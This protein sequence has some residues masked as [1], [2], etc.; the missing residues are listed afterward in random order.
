MV[1]YKTINKINGK[2][3]IGQDTNN[4]PNYLGSG[5]IIKK[6]IKK[7]GR[8]NFKKEILEEC[9]TIELL[10]EREIYWISKFDSMDQKIGY[11]ILKGG[12]GCSGFKQSD[13]SIIKIRK[14]SNSE[15]FKNIMR[16]DEVKKKIS[17]GQKNSELKKAL[18]Y[19]EEYREKMRI[20][21]TGKPQSPEKS[22]KISDKLKGKAKSEEHKE[23]L[24]IALTEGGKL[25]GENN[26][27]YNKK[28]T[29]ESRKK[30]T[31]GLKKYYNDRKNKK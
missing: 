16:S 11:N 21:M 26:P 14:N 25:L 20:S 8:S 22:K 5:K 28:H 30:M 19:S 27:F 12:L 18:H 3:Y 15:K 17:E 31:E 7:Y 1:I 10:N 9:N 24:R 4:D 2:I 6:A 29:E 13:E 23:N